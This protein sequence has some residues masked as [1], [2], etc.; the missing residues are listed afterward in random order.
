M[1]LS[2]PLTVAVLASRKRLDLAWAALA[3]LGV[4]LLSGALEGGPVDR[5][6]LAVA[7]V[8]AG[9]WAAYILV[10]LVL[11]GQHLGARDAVAVCCVVVA[12][13]GAARSL[14]PVPAEF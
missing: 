13:L 1:E 2:G 9:G 7:F 6:G 11:L 8:A 5:V 10:G 3:A 12:S 14:P 4:L